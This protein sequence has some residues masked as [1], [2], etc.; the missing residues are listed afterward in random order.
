MRD[1]L[2]LFLLHLFF[3]NTFSFYKLIIKIITQPNY[4]SK[5]IFDFKKMSYRIWENDIT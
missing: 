1:S 5:S 3:L 2:P 4:Y